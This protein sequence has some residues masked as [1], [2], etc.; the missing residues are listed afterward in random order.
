MTA[1]RTCGGCVRDRKPC[2]T[3]ATLQRALA[4]L[5]M[6]SVK[7]RCQDRQEPYAPGDAVYARTA[8]DFGTPDEPG[9]LMARFPGVLVRILGTKAVVFIKPD[10]DGLDDNGEGVIFTPRNS[11]G[12][13]KLP[14]LRI[15]ARDAPAE[16]FCSKCGNPNSAPHANGCE[17]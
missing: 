5:H 10:E 12:F 13:C 11:D 8:V 7:W 3:R 2:D 15:E 17:P 9:L 1:Y 4:G 16:G 6:T 14:L